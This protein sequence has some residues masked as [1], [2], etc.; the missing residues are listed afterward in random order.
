[1]EE[2]APTPGGA[3]EILLG[4]GFGL[5]FELAPGGDGQRADV[6]GRAGEVGGDA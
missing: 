5:G 1:M 6:F 3:L 4:C 2:R